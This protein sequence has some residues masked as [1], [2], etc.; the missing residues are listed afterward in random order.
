MCTPNSL[1]NS[2]FHSLNFDYALLQDDT[3]SER[4][5]EINKLLHD[6]KTSLQKDSE[7]AIRNIFHP[8]YND[9]TDDVSVVGLG[10]IILQPKSNIQ[11]QV[12]AYNSRVFNQRTRTFHVRS[13]ALR[14]NFSNHHLRIYHFWLKCINYS[15]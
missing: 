12:I 3:S 14:Y 7:I 13:R 2:K 6:I 15:F 5:P 11:L 9:I 1:P 8:F 4:L 10:A